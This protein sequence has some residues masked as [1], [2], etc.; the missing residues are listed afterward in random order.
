MDTGALYRAVALA[1]LNA[2]LD[3]EDDRKLQE[4]FSGLD[5]KFCRSAQGVRLMSGERD[6]THDI[7]TPEISMLASAISARPVVRN[8]LLAMQRALGRQK[9]AVFEGRDMGTV[10]FPDADIKFYLDAASDIRADRRFEELKSDPRITRAEVARS[11][12]QRDQNDSTRAV[13]PL[14]PAFDAIR[15]DSSHLNAEQVVALMLEHVNRRA[16]QAILPGGRMPIK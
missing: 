1:A 10:V 5:L 11:I 12:R 15:I 9:G 4:L 6:I 16:S 3:P 7:R 2:G 14:R 13:A 8:C